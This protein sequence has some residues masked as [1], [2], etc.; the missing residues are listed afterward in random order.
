[1]S[2]PS[3]GAQPIDC[4][5]EEVVAQ[6]EGT[7]DERSRAEEASGLGVEA[8]GL[9][10]A[11]EALE[12]PGRV[13]EWIGIRMDREDAWVFGVRVPEPGGGLDEQPS[14]HLAWIDP[15]SA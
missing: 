14:R 10:C 15:P 13:S 5:R 11:G 3:F 6:V 9:C 7:D 1:M 8:L 12:Y 2:E 4:H